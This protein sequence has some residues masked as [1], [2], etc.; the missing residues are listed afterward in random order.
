MDSGV[1]DLLLLQSIGRLN[2]KR[3]RY[4]YV[5]LMYEIYFFLRFLF[6]FLKFK[7]WIHGMNE[8][9]TWVK[10]SYAY[11][12]FFIESLEYHDKN[13]RLAFA[14]IFFFFLLH[15]ILSS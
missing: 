5:C 4:D 10:F 15:S 2:V 14:S 3:Y 13:I 11:I 1:H 9:R 12:T 6:L 7:I 8:I